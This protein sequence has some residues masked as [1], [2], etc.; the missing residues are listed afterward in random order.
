MAIPSPS[1]RLR[2]ECQWQE[3]CFANGMTMAPWDRELIP[4]FVDWKR[5]ARKLLLSLVAFASFACA[6][7]AQTPAPEFMP[8][9]SAQPILQKMDAGN[10]SGPSASISSQDWIAWLQKSDAQVRQRL[11]TGEEDS[12]TNLLRFGVTYTKEYR[13]DD[14]Y[15]VLYGQSSLVN[16]FAENRANDLIKALATPNGN[17]GFIEMRTFLE[18]RGF[19]LNSPAERKKLKAYLLANLARMQK[20]FLQARE[21]AKANRDQMFEHRGISLDS[22]LWPDYD[23]DLSLQT[24]L[25]QGRLKPGTIQRVAIVGPGLDFVNKQQGVDY[26]PPQTTQPFAVLD[27]LVRLGLSNPQIVEVYTLDISP[28]VNVHIQAAK[29]NAAAGR[30]Y[31]VQLP[32]FTEGRWSDDFRASFTTYWQRL[33]AQIGQPVAAIQV[34]PGSPGFATR[35]VKIRSAVV[36]RIKPVDMNIVYQRL[37]LAPGERFDL[38]IGT[39]IFLYY[40]GFEQSLARANVASML[41]P[42]GY[43]LSND[44]LPD[45]V[46][47]GL[48]QVEVTEIPMTG[49]P[50]MTDYIYCYR[51]AE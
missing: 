2:P 20:E 40:G 46:P 49:P 18:K 27:S 25:K 34:P 17:Q 41:K 35:A 26:Y 19:S 45:T 37:P 11:D 32:W 39:N 51:R 36:N 13:I 44:K 6:T 43:L 42:G 48:E 14:E 1:R 38:V 21:Q 47:S 22:N 29:K 10:S 9:Y 7:S 16:A 24:L 5:A 3:K 12:L 23:L 33:G 30:D 28:R 4:R 50:V 31:T 15:L 8:L